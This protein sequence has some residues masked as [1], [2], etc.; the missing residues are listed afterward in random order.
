MGPFANSH[1]GKFP[2]S[3]HRYWR[4]TTRRCFMPLKP[5]CETQPIRSSSN[6]LSRFNPSWRTI[7][8]WAK[9]SGETKNCRVTYLCRRD[10]LCQLV[11][12][13]LCEAKRRKRERCQGGLAPHSSASRMEGSIIEFVWFAEKNSLSFQEVDVVSIQSFLT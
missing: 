4:E 1:L 3:H 8:S 11:K 5:G 12:T 13:K 10:T 6:L 9:R 7:S 2:I